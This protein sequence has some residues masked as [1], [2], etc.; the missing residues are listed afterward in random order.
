MILGL[1]FDVCMVEL[2]RILGGFGTGCFEDISWN[3]LV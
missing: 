1:M 3:I 2:Y